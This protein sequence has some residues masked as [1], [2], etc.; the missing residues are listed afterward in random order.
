MS[1]NSRKDFFKFAFGFMG[2]ISL[3]FAV[4]VGVG[5]YEMEISGTGALSDD[6]NLRFSLNSN[7]RGGY[8]D[9]VDQKEKYGNQ[10]DWAGRHGG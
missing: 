9:V 6:A 2:M 4:L 8:L 1:N 10:R 7:R 3:G 5:F